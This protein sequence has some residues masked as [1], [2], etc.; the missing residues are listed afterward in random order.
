MI[1]LFAGNKGTTSTGCQGPV[2]RWNQIHFSPTARDSSEKFTPFSSLR[3]AYP[4]IRLELPPSYISDNNHH[5]TYRDGPDTDIC[6]GRIKTRD[7]FPPGLLSGSWGTSIGR[8]VLTL[9]RPAGR[10][11]FPA[12]ITAGV[13]LYGPFQQ[14]NLIL[15]PLLLLSS[16][17]TFIEDL[18][19]ANV[20]DDFSHVQHPHYSPSFLKFSDK[21]SL[22]RCNI[23]EYEKCVN[24]LKSQLANR[25]KI[26]NL[27]HL[28]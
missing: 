4:F 19:Q 6:E 15:L 12:S 17:A 28:I 18:L 7:R 13:A 9:V 1:L 3:P 21:I 24:D 16:L 20:P 22:N 26:I 27:N 23:A 25:I 14:K 10:L 11:S 5:N 8:P 2:F